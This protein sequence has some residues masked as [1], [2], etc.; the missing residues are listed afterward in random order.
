M[1]R[2]YEEINGYQLERFEVLTEVLLRI[3]GM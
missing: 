2:I 1:G 3:F